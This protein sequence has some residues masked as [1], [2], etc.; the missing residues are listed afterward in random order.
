[1]FRDLPAVDFYARLRLNGPVVLGSAQL[2]DDAVGVALF[3][4]SELIVTLSYKLVWSWWIEKERNQ[5]IGT[6]YVN[7]HTHHMHI[8]VHTP[9]KQDKH[10][11]NHIL[12][13]FPMISA[14]V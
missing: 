11:Y 8:H 2:L 14:I 9:G 12:T 5:I 13:I 6:K 3:V 4:E 10:K 1:V 7:T